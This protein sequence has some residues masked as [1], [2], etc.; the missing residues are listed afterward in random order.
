MSDVTFPNTDELTP[1]YTWTNPATDVEYTWNGDRW[2]IVDTSE[3]IDLQ[4]VLVNGNVS[5]QS[6]VLTN[7]SD[8][9]LLLS[10]E[11]GRIMVGGV[12]E[13]V[14]P[15][16]ELRHSQGAL[17][18]SVA[19]LEIDEGGKRFDVECDEKI[20]NIHFRF[21]DDVKLELNKNGD[22]VFK[23]GVEVEGSVKSNGLTN[24]GNATFNG[25]TTFKF[26]SGQGVIA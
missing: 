18:T 15:S 20:D 24:N 26:G 13:D 11:E 2:I 6:I 14:V 23:G 9:A 25:N 21:N 22:A 19:K 12:G 8:D 4:G 17:E 5:D 1:G 10:P 16:I 3:G 7:G